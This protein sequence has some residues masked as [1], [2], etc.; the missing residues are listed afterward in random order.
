MR[1]QKCNGYQC[2]AAPVTR[3]QSSAYCAGCATAF[4]ARLAERLAA[5]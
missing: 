1:D 2:K 5:R 4:R 3:V